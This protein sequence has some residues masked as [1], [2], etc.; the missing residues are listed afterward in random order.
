MKVCSHLPPSTV[1][2]I[3]AGRGGSHLCMYYILHTNATDQMRLDATLNFRDHS[4]GYKQQN[5]TKR[6]KHDTVLTRNEH[7]RPNALN[8]LV[9]ATVSAERLVNFC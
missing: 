7:R 3:R 2:L 8:I 6:T 9:F 4:E 5:N 1:E